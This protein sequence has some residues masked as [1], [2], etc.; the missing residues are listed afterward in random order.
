MGM[1]IV[2]NTC[3]QYLPTQALGL[4]T[5]S[6]QRHLYSA[7]S[8]YTLHLW[9]Q[10]VCMQQ[11]R[12]PDRTPAIFPSGVEGWGWGGQVTPH[13]P[14]PLCNISIGRFAYSQLGGQ[15]CQSCLTSDLR[16]SKLHRLNLGSVVRECGEKQ[17]ALSVRKHFEWG[18][19]RDALM[20]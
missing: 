11:I 16:K 3:T 18:K 19:G 15:S 17:L 12:Q 5:V 7:A 9:C 2:C 13:Y 4:T 1:H 6:T 14:E 20:R 10:R 8:P